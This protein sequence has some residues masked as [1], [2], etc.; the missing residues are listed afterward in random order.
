MTLRI[1]LLINP[2][3]GIGG[4]AAL[5]G[6]DQDWRQALERGIAPQAAARAQRFV[7]QVTVHG[8]HVEWLTCPGAMGL[9]GL[10]RIDGT[11]KAV[12]D[13]S[14]A[15][16]VAMANALRDAGVDLLCFVGGD[17]TAAD[18]AGAV[19]DS[20]PCLGIPGGVKITSAVFAHDPDQAAWLVAN[21]EPG[22]A[23]IAR[24]VTDLDEVAYRTG[25][26]DVEL[27]GSLN[28]PES[29][30]IQAGKVASGGDTPLEPIVE[31]VLRDWDPDALHLVGAGSVCRAIKQQFWGEPTLLGVDAIRGDRIIQA[32]LDADAI[33]ALLDAHDEVHLWLTIIGG[34]GMLLGRGTQMLRPGALRRIGWDRIHA[35]AAP[36]KLLGLRGLRVDTGDPELDDSAPSHVRVIAGWNEWRLLRVLRGP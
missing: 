18:V 22:F 36:E 26:V 17:G 13:T 12:G 10:A 6:S 32:D 20:V 27:K 23:T 11:G 15:D 34:Q 30:A 35:V 19:G 3:A 8:G 16:T 4:P 29:P 28:V 21:L 2:I 33:D 14:A 5:K 25:D 1:G 24:D 31:Q 7:D 9:D